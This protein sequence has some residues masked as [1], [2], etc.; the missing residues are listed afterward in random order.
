MALVTVESLSP[1]VVYGAKDLIEIMQN[2]RDILTTRKG[3]QPLDR[4][5]G[6]S[7][8]FIDTPA[9]LAKANA[10][11]EIFLQVRKY[12]PRVEIRQILWAVEVMA[13]KFLPKLVVEIRN[14]I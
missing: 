13:G 6:I 1:N 11:Q 10:E 2:L 3:T 12:E 7:F 4:A 8:D 14:G 5:F 9:P